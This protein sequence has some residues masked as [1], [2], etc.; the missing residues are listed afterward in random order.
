M[1]HASR[2][3]A[4]LSLALIVLAT[5]AVHAERLKEIAN[6]GG[7]RVNQLVGYGLVV[8]LDGTGDKANSS[9][10]MRQSMS[11]MLNQLGVMV[12]PDQKIDPKNAAA[13]MVTAVLPP[14]ARSG[15]QIDVVVSAM[16]DAKSL[17]GGTLLLSPLKGADGQIYAMSQGN[18]M[19]GGAGAGGGGSST[20]INQLNGGRIPNGATVEREVP[21]TVGQNDIVAVELKTAD[22]SNASRVVNAING[23]MG[24]VARAVDAGRIDVRAPA[25]PNA[26]VAFLGK[27]ENLDVAM[28]SPVARVIVNARTGSVVMNQTVRVEPCAVAH[29][30]LTVTV[31]STPEV[32]Q[33]NALSQGQTTTTTQTSTSIQSDGGRLVSVPRGTNLNEIVRALNAVGATPQDLLSILQAMKASGALRAE[34]EVI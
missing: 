31:Q 34:L 2:L 6:I 1:T 16:G 4:S 19:V 9:P 14:F 17:R 23:A 28:S 5:P 29:G 33:P 26:R 30:N 20:K 15:Q 24:S 18:I 11:N 13:V 12:P 27:L 8:G 10:F 7:M 32:S 3:L 21:T 25:D 22:F